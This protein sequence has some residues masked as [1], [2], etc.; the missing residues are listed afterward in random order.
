MITIPKLIN[1]G[2]FVPI[3]LRIFSDLIS[4]WLWFEVL[5]LILIS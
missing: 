1:L 4:I 3:I 2:G 5:L